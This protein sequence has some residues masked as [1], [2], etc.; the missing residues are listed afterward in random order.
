MVFVV[1]FQFWEI[2]SDE[3]GI[4]KTGHYHGDN[5]MQLERIDV[6]YNEAAA[7]NK[8]TPSYYFS[9]PTNQT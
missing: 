9:Q 5:D 4:D 8:F 7:G 6:Y 1:L 3:H 2:I